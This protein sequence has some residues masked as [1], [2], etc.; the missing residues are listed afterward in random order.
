MSIASLP[1]LWRKT[2]TNCA[3]QKAI[4]GQTK[5]AVSQQ[6]YAAIHRSILS[7][8]LSHI[9][10]KEEVRDYKATRNQT[11][12]LHPASA[13]KKDPPEWL[14]AAEIV[15]TSRLFAKSA[16]AIDPIWLE[17]LGN[18]LISKSWI[19]PRWDIKSGTVLA[20]EQSR[21]YGF[22]VARGKTVP[23]GPVRPMETRNIFIRSALVESSPADLSGYDFLKHNRKL[24]NRLEAMEIKLRRRDLLVGDEAIASFYHRQLPPEVLDIATLNRAL[25]TV[26]YLDKRLQLSE[27]DLLTGIDVQQ[28]LKQFPN[29]VELAGETWKLN[30]VFDP[31]SKRDGVTLNIP[32]GRLSQVSVPETDWMVPGLIKDKTEAL[33]RNLPKPLRRKISPIA[34]TARAAFEGMKIEGDLIHSLSHWLYHERGIDIPPKEWDLDA[35]PAYL[36]VRYRL[37][38]DAGREVAS[39]YDLSKLV[40]TDKQSTRLAP[41]GPAARYKDENEITNLKDWPDTMVTIPECV[42]IRGNAVLWGG[43]RDDEDSVSV[44]YFDLQKEADTSHAKGQTRL[45]LIYWARELRGFRQQLQLTDMARAVAHYAGGPLRIENAIWERT[46]AE[47]FAGKLVRNKPDWL[48]VRETGGKQLF[49]T[50]HNYMNLVSTILVSYG[51]LRENLTSLAKKSYRK[52]YIAGCQDDADALISRNFIADLPP[53]VWQSIPRWFKAMEIRARRGVDDPAREQKFSAVWHPLFNRFKAM[54]DNLSPM[55]TDRKRQMLADA[56]IMLE[57]LRVVLSAAGEIKP[58]EKISESKMKRFWMRLKEFYKCCTIIMQGDK[59]AIQL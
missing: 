14:V 31:E 28:D 40:P 52:N 45:G 42:P 21:L 12:T 16:A 51:K 11:V 19:N 30:Y 55:A 43:L 4:H 20:E 8:L 29:K 56:G 22:L 24:L 44:S 2:G 15:R 9:A 17:E 6:R 41:G 49:S 53:E 59:Y 47:V 3:A 57:E 35:L 46:A 13:L 10:Q 1:W 23:Y 5:K 18:H 34:D 48:I 27:D 36:K 39:G 7:G 54:E 26:K 38:S 25:K 37:L 58:A 33:M 50:A 32:S